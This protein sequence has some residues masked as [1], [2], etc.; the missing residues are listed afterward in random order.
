MK[1]TEGTFE[2]LAAVLYEDG[3]PFLEHYGVKGMHW[4][5]R[6]SETLARYQRNQANKKSKKNEAKQISATAKKQNKIDRQNEIVNKER[7]KAILQDRKYANKNRSLL[8]E[9]ELDDRIRRL[10]KERQLYLL[11]MQELEPGK[12]AVQNALMGVGKDVI[13][14]EGNSI[15]KG[16]LKKAKSG[17]PKPA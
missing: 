17:L 1:T 4:G 7:R 13:S 14:K 5:V 2:N 11:T 15:A 6:N 8:T 9:Q 12:Y 10:Q 3:E 16:A